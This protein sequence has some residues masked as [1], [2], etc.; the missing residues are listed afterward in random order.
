MNNREKVNGNLKIKDTV[1]WKRRK[2]DKRNKD[3]GQT[4]QSQIMTFLQKQC[5]G[6]R[7]QESQQPQK[8]NKFVQY[9][10]K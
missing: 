9:L 5:Q 4:L 1:L 2:K 3:N 7:F 6:K 10:C 8:K